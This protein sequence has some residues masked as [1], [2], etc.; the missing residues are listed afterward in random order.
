[1]P[2]A[3]PVTLAGLAVSVAGNVGHVAGHSAADRR[4][5]RCPRSPRPPRWRS[6]SASSSGR[7]KPPPGEADVRRVPADLV[8]AAEASLR[9]TIAAG[10]ALS[11]N[12]LAERFSLTR[13]QATKL[14]S[15]VLAEANGHP[16]E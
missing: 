2:G 7:A 8:A 15:T 10:N 14:R 1:M 4:P 5:P 6:G 12:Q 11:V 13:T 3:W 16:T 9:A